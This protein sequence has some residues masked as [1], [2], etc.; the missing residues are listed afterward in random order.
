MKFFI[1]FTLSVLVA[2]TQTPELNAPCHDFG[3]HCY[4]LPINED[5][6]DK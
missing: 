6:G 5:L 1:L 4:Q 3:K 2:C